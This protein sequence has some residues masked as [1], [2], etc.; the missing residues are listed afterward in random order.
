[1]TS[2]TLQR[3]PYVVFGAGKVAL[4]PELLGSYGENVVIVTGGK[5][6]ERSGT[7]AALYERIQRESTLCRHVAIDGEPSPEVI[8]GAVEACRD[9]GINVVAA[10]GGGSVIDAGKAVSAMLP[11]R[12]PVE[13]FIEGLPGYC[14]PDGRKVPFIAVPTTSGTGSEATNNAVISRAGKNGYKRSLRHDAFVPDMALLDPELTLS[15]PVGLT[16]SSGMDALTQL[17]EALVS[18]DGSPFTEAVALNGLEYVVAYFS[19]ACR[20]GEHDIEARSGM[21]YAAYL[22][23]VALVNAG[24]GIVHGFASSIGGYI[25]I[26]HGRLCATLLHAA[27]AENIAIL[28]QQGIRGDDVLASYAKAGRLFAGDTYLDDDEACDALLEKLESMQEELD[29]P[30]LGTFGFRN[31]DVDR[32]ISRT[33][34]K[35]KPVELDGNSLRRILLQRL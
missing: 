32:V 35:S 29:I 25:D 15:M 27:T 14:K 5:T 18:P 19:R 10:L 22:S 24:L 30:R 16:V 6:L 33:R 26:P 8:D 13:R 34:N 7:I 3:Q 11:S 31:G 2:F 12:E 23:G 1:M 17:L 4:L 9:S 20:N 21:S 28:R